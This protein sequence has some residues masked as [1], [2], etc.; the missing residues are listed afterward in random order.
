LKS[1]AGAEWQA[2]AYAILEQK[3]EQGEPTDF[4]YFYDI[5]YRQAM[6]FAQTDFNW[7]EILFVTGGISFSN[8]EQFIRGRNA[9]DFQFDTTTT[10]GNT[11][12]PRFAFSIQ[13]IKNLYLYRSYSAGVA[14]P[15][16]FEMIDQENNAYNLS[17]SSEHGNLHEIGLKHHIQKMGLDYSLTAYQFEITDAILPYSVDLTDGESVQRY[18]ND[19]S[20]I[21]RGLEWSLR[22]ET[23]RHSQGINM[24]FWNNGTINNHRFA[25]YEVNETILNN[26]SIPGVPKAQMNTGLQLEFNGVSLSVFDYWMDRLP[27]NNENT[28]WTS[29]YHLMN[30]MARYK[31]DI[32]KQF[33]CSIHAGM[34]NTLNAEYSSF[35]SINGANGRFYNPSAPR[36]FFGGFQLNYTLQDY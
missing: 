32:S 3:I 6:A 4:K 21:Q 2:E 27:V 14:N 12:M 25:S 17:L 29:S 28:V 26:N 1:T 30:L 15:T 19:G 34:N 36:N 9:A 22:Y 8:N 24:T 18:H 11:V 20:T 33:S 10:W 23:P 16:V 35:L 31:W 13:P 7:K 5:G